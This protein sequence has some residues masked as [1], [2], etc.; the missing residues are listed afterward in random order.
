MQRVPISNT[1]SMC[2]QKKNLPSYQPAWNRVIWETRLFHSRVL[3]TSFL[4]LGWSQAKAYSWSQEEEGQQGHWG[5]ERLHI[6]S[7][8][9][10][11]SMSWGSYTEE[12]G[13]TQ[14]FQKFQWFLK[15]LPLS[16]KQNAKTTAWGCTFE[17][18]FRILHCLWK[19]A[20]YFGIKNVDNFNLVFP[21]SVSFDSVKI[22]ILKHPLI[23]YKTYT[24]K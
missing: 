9:G 1:I 2:K 5:W 20:V 7:M 8:V 21:I 15:Q 3:L 12:T 22:I 4:Y 18:W 17:I 24:E 6:W 16:T 11:Q 19:S 10:S 14:Y 13:L 23:T